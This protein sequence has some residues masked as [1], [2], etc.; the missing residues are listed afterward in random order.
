L[1]ARWASRRSAAARSCSHHKGRL[2]VSSH[3][4]HTNTWTRTWISW[5]SHWSCEQRVRTSPTTWRSPRPEARLGPAT[6][7]RACSHT[8]ARG[9]RCSVEGSGLN[10]W[11]ESSRAAAYLRGLRGGLALRAVHTGKVNHVQPRLQRCREYTIQHLRTVLGTIQYCTYT[12]RTHLTTS[13]T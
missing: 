13:Q 11:A 4:Q 8:S 1:T 3:K 7:R 6:R 2:A 5:T 12:Q 10:P 9:P